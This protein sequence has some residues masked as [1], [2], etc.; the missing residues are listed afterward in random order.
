M[1]SE[2]SDRLVVL[3][4]G[5]PGAGKSTLAPSL[6][7]ALG[8]PLFGKDTIKEIHADVLGSSPLDDRSQREWNSAFGRAASLTQW[9]L[10]AAAPR[11]AVLESSWRA[12]VRPLVAEGLQSAGGGRVVEVWCDVPFDV[13]W[14]RYCT[15]WQNNHP[16]HGA[17]MTSQEWDRMTQHAQ[18]LA[19]GPVRR[20]D[21]TQP[22]DAEDLA[23]WCRA[24]LDLPSDLRLSGD[25]LILRDWTD[26]D[27]PALLELFDDPQT[28]LHY[29]LGATL[30]MELGERY[31]ERQRQFRTEGRRIDL[32]ITLEGTKPIGQL[33]ISLDGEKREGWLGGTVAAA[34]RNQGIARRAVS[35]LVDY[36]H[37]TSQISRF[38]AQIDPT[39][40]ASI[41]AAESLGLVRTDAP[42]ET[43]E[44]AGRTFT[45][46]T[47]ELNIA[48]SSSL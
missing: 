20:V 39:N 46:L 27:V 37:N 30:D 6:S 4:N 17:L 26:D 19:L 44:H 35:V 11:G 14:E 42:P 13:A 16:I 34:Y 25:G 28:D 21:T 3:V 32:A 47:W 43:T 9:A 15:R 41:T 2:Q 38:V 23:A 33:G 31:I 7:R 40:L 18:P 1:S 12:D 24:A 45:V 8:L 22:V 29:P 10:L 48:Q 5:I 36:L